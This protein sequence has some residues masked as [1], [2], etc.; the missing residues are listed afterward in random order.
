MSWI[1]LLDE[2]KL[3]T[4]VEWKVVQYIKENI[5]KI[6]LM[7]I[8][9][10]AKVT[11]TSNATI[12]RTCRKLKCNGYKELKRRLIKEI[13]SQKHIKHT[14]DFTIPFY[15]S[16][17]VLEIVNNIS[18]L[19]KESIDIINA[20]LD[21]DILE[22]IVKAIFSAKRLFVYSI[23][24]SR[25]TAKSFI[26]KLIK[27]NYYAISATDNHEEI[28]ISSSAKSQDCALFISYSGESADL[29]KCFHI[30]KRSG[31]KVI[32]IT[33]NE[34]SLIAT[35][36]DMCILLPDKENDNKIATFYS[37]LAFQYVLNI[38]YSLLYAKLKKANKV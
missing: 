6:T 1:K 9:Q 18:N 20:N 14:V 35:K 13:E 38:I 30:L 34:N 12:L 16:E 36:S 29:K 7:N 10:L 24:D 8:S 4:D 3:F 23:G 22:Q 31:C 33:A 15:S 27:I 11:Y 5:S 32:T 37:Q 26:N 19:Y 25:I 17:T 21:I 2:R 28:F